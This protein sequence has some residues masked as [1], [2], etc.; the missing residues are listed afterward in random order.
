MKSRDYKITIVIGFNTVWK[1]W[2]CVFLTLWLISLINQMNGLHARSA[3]GSSTS[4]GRLLVDIDFAEIVWSHFSGN[5]V[6][7]GVIQT[8][9]LVLLYI[10]IRKLFKLTEKPAQ[11]LIFMNLLASQWDQ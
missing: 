1:K 8:G 11:Y 10:D 9:L 2:P 3:R 7:F 4:H 5:L 6:T